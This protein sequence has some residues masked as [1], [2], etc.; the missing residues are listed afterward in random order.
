MPHI[1]SKEFK[2][3]WNEAKSIVVNAYSEFDDRFGKIAN[4]FFENSWIHATVKRKDFWSFLAPYS[5]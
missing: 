5:T 3:N 4:L 1:Q 2:I